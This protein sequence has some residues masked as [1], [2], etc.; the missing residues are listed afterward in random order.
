MTNK[1]WE[2]CPRCGEK[3]VE[4][5]SRASEKGGQVAGWFFAI[6]LVGGL[7]WVAFG[8]HVIALPMFLFL[9]GFIVLGL[10]AVSLL[11]GAAASSGVKGYK[12]K[13]KVCSYEWEIS[14]ERA[15]ELMAQT[16]A[17]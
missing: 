10:I 13:C 3:H 12:A 8:G 4:V 6:I 7:I 11:V 5:Y 15:K 14:E 16:H 9:G 17:Q 2:P 1:P